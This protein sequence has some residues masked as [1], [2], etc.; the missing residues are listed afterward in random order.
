M[1]TR[2]KIA[3]L[4]TGGTIAGLAPSA[5]ATTGYEAGRLGV[6]ALMEAAVGIERLADIQG[7]QI[8][9]IDSANMRDAIWLR[10]AAEI[11]KLFAEGVDGI[12][13]THGTDTMEETAYFL[14]LTLKSDKPVV[15]TGAMRP[16]TA[17]GADGPKNLYNAVALA[18]HKDARGVMIAMNDR[19]LSARGATKVHSLNV[20][21]FS[22]CENLGY[23]VDGRVHFGEKCAKIPPFDVSA[24]RTLPQV[25]I[26]YTYSNDGSGVA[27]RAFF[28][29]GTR[30][31][32]VAGSGAGSIHEDSKS[33]LKTLMREGLRVVV[34]SR[35]ADA[36]VVLSE[37]DVRLGFVGAGDLNPQ[38]ARILLMLALTKTKDVE[39][40]REY[41]LKC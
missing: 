5:V 41:F 37:E 39:K 30:G 26:I 33:V 10:L 21:A 18:A 40:I 13:I 8:A 24:L 14:H 29:N 36:R 2:A 22:S 15:L 25:D 23:I 6:E 27:A 32:V 35:V 1:Q 31:I 4:A 28:E 3:I 19:I 11:P 38:K 16:S 20:D 34:S 7:R 17:M 12:V 9:N